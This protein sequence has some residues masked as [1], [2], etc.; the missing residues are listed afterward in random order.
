MPINDPLGPNVIT[1]LTKLINGPGMSDLDFPLTG[2][3]RTSV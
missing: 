2:W 3:K 1:K